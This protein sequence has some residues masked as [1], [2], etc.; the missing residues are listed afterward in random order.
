MAA[1]PD[2]DG[3]RIV[4]LL[5]AIA[6]VVGLGCV[7]IVMGIAAFLGVSSSVGCSTS[8]G[9]T[10]TAPIGTALLQAIKYDAYD[11]KHNVNLTLAMLGGSHLESGWNTNAVG[12]GSYG[13]WQIQ[14]STH[15][16]VTK[17]QALDPAFSTNYM[18]PA[19]VAGMKNVDPT[20]WSLD[21]ELA[22]E[23]TAYNAERPAKRYSDGRQADVHAAFLASVKAMR[24]MG[25]PITFGLNLGVTTQILPTI[26][27]TPGPTVAPTATPTVSAS[28]SPVPTEDCGTPISTTAAGAAKVVL[29]SADTQLGV[30]YVMGGESPR[31]AD[32]P[33]FP[34]ALDCSG[35]V[36]WAF[37]TA[38]IKLPRL[39]H[40][41]WN[42]TKSRQVSLSQAQPGDLVF[43]IGSE[44]GAS[45]A[46]PKHVGIVYDPSK[47]I[48]IV[49][50]RTGEN[51]KYENYTKA[52]DLVGI[53]HPYTDSATAPGPSQGWQSP[54][55]PGSYHI[56]SPFGMR[57]HPT[58]HH[59]SLHDG[60]DLGAPQG[61]PIR[62]ASNGTVIRADYTANAYGNYTVIQHAGG[63]QT[64]YAHQV[65]RAP[66]I[67]VG[68]VVTKGQIIG[69]VGQTGPATGPHL[70]FNVKVHGKWVDPAGPD[71]FMTH[72][73]VIL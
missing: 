6:M 55:T 59:W 23:Q 37:R 31:T 9:D 21:P 2:N 49:A 64:G 5:V 42:A 51:V 65:R 26:K 30:P 53:T 20:L 63:I 57:W 27:P 69:Y 73:G 47:G 60:V 7:G 44:A 1:G 14:L 38:G 3:S 22:M 45:R 62:A 70:H 28:A 40:E 58:K 25:I 67:H 35:L 41:Q 16:D 71:G 32:R 10:G 33:G 17:A 72:H 52:G 11:T 36:Q 56:T 8:G 61:T 12:A 66:G 13:P 24:E 48:M 29:D 4:A 18:L 19:Y 39:A 50:P 34:G 43:F 46:V 54:L 15:P 68:S